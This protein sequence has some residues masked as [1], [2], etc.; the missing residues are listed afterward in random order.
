[1]SYYRTGFQQQQAANVQDDNIEESIRRVEDVL[2]EVQLEWRYLT[3]EDFNPVILALS[4]LDKSSLGKDINA[5]KALLLKLET[6]MDAVVN[7]YYQGFNNSTTTY[8]AVKEKIKETQIHVKKMKNTIQQCKELLHVQRS[9][10]EKLWARSNTYKEMIRILDVVEDLRKVPDEIEELIQ[11]KHYY[12]ATTRLLKSLEIAN[13]ED[14]LKINALED[15]RQYLQNMKNTLHEVLTEELHKHIYLKSSQNQVKPING[16]V[17]TVKLPNKQREQNGINKEESEQTDEY[18]AVDDVRVDPETD[19]LSYTETLLETLYVL[20][21]L[22]SALESIQQRVPIELYQ[23]VDRIVEEVDSRAK[24]EMSLFNPEKRYTLLAS[25]GLQAIQQAE[26]EM[27]NEILRDFT[28]TLYSKLETMLEHHKFV[29]DVSTKIQKRNKATEG[30][31]NP[32]TFKEVWMSVQSEVKSMLYDY[33]IDT[34]KGTSIHKSIP[35]V[36]DMLRNGTQVRDRNKQLFQLGESVA[37]ISAATLYEHFE[38]NLLKKLSSTGRVNAADGTDSISFT[39]IINDKFANSGVA[40]GHR[41][42]VKPDVYHIS[43]VIKPT[44]SFLNRL[45]EVLPTGISEASDFNEFLDDFIVTVFLPRMQERVMES[46]SNFADVSDSF[47]VD[48]DFRDYSEYPL[49]KSATTLVS[50]VDSLCEV[51]HDMPLH[52]K[53]YITVIEGLLKKYREKCFTRFKATVTNGSNHIDE[54]DRS[55]LLS[56]MW[57]ENEEIVS[58]LK[59]SRTLNKSKDQESPVDENLLLQEI[60]LETKLKKERSLHPSELVVDSKKLKFLATLHH[61]LMWL[62]SK[63]R[64]LKD[65]NHAACIPL[66]ESIDSVPRK[67][68]LADEPFRNFDSILAEFQQ[69]ADTCLFMLHIEFRCQ[70]MYYLDLATREGNYYLTEAAQEPDSYIVTLNT[71][72]VNF[73]ECMT[74]TLPVNELSFVFSGLSYLM[75]HVLI[76]NIRYI[77]QMNPAGISKMV[78]NILA[79]KQNLANIA[80]P[81]L[82]GN[83]LDEAKTYYSLVALSPQELVQYAGEHINSFTFE[84]Y[85]YLLSLIQESTEETS[86]TRNYVRE[87]YDCTLSK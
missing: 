81:Q 39:S 74:E 12:T 65:Q 68:P 33:L 56:A 64:T 51:L 4:L 53:E 82:H 13:E 60:T 22:P 32:Y 37:K 29:L 75:S 73:E 58:L 23:L 67:S 69:L 19:S 50:T 16:G 76:T 35:S 85:K 18:H 48:P 70:S 42:L 1:M 43:I 20:G 24:R 2:S 63:I 79:L 8:S 61:T 26:N 9:D 77:K 49:F 87:L 47:H 78:R 15:L 52:Q 11:H 44:L 6:A 66:E 46:F 27:S 86:D 31:P 72:L 21:K 17:D 45:K 10:L 7:D 41:L 34:Q 71:T 84:Q 14:L 38:T 3:S 5:F 54:A 40:T 55:V 25:G 36:R 28:T 83:G 59:Q 30:E 80:V 62:V 57:A